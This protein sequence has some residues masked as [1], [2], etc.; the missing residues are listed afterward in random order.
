MSDPYA[1]RVALSIFLSLTALVV[2]LTWHSSDVALVFAISM[3][4]AAVFT[5]PSPP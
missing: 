2:A 4:V 1:A 3:G 5:C